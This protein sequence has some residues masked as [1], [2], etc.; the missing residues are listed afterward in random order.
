M[1]DDVQLLCKT[2]KVIDIVALKKPEVLKFH[3]LKDL[4][5]LYFPSLK[6]F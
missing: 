1:K 2:G 6:S 4:K 5:M 3:V